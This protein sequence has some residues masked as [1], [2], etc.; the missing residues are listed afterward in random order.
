MITTLAFA[1]YRS[2]RRLVLPLSGLTVIAGANGAGKSNVY[3][4]LRL[5]AAAAAGGHQNG[6][7]AA[8][9]RE[10]GL[11]SALWAGPERGSIDSVAR[12][13]PVQGTVRTERVRLKLGFSTESPEDGFGYALELGLPAPG[14]A[15]P[16]AFA[17]D[18]EIKT[19]SLF[20][21]EP[22]RPANTLIQRTGAVV[23]YRVT[24]RRW[25]VLAKHVPGYDSVFD[26]AVDPAK[27]PEIAQLRQGLRNW[28]FYDHLRTDQDAPARRTQV[29]TRTPVLADGGDD[30]AAALQTVVEI[31]DADRLADAIDDAF[32]G[33]S[34]RID[35]NRGQF[36]LTLQRAGLLRPLAA[37]EL[38]DGTLRY[39][40]LLAALLS[41][42]PPG[43]LVLNE[44]ET[45]LHPDLTEPLARLIA[46][47][48]TQV[49]VVTH[50][51][52][53]VRALERDSACSVLTLENR[54]GE[55]GVAGLRELDEPAWRWGTD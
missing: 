26:S 5:L 31:G 18:P 52:A 2:L 12:G 29:G 4:G 49:I 27:A 8:L 11:Q 38:S 42:R 45:S 22:L 55:T 51:S 6:M 32:P 53:L 36:T 33:A 14:N 25:D 9:A 35:V 15:G 46:G 24:G 47:C 13:L 37:P 40:M 21:G 1:N 17:L 23:K 39:L 43:L 3:R 30:L 28:R 34:L 44:P 48:A 7:I 20:A 10:G 16:S 50:A 41:P 54:Q 19:E